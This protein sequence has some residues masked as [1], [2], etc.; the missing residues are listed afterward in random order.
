MNLSEI[1][2]YVDHT[3]LATTAT[4]ADVKTIIDDA[5]A[6]RT[7]SI[8]IPPSYVKRAVTYSDGRIPVCTVIGF[9]NGYQTTETKVFE[10]D[11]AVKNGAAEIDMVINLGHVKDGRFDL[12]LAE[13]RAVRDACA[14]RILKVIVETSQL[15]EAEKIELCNVVSEA[16]ADFIKTST[17]FGGGGATVEDV[18][19]FRQHVAAAVSIKASGGI[20]SK[21]DAEQLILAG[22]ARLGTSRLVA[23]AKEELA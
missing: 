21:E 8:C 19:L 17:G 11:D 23:L 15:T 16:G 22:A 18:Q 14:G 3:L 13:I 6:W 2:T 20:R 9:P 12:V 10:T 1:L 7:S 5:V 4:W